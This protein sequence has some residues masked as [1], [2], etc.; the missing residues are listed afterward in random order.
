[1]AT[2]QLTD[3]YH[4]SLS[5]GKALWDDL[6]GTALPVEIKSGHFD[7]GK[8]AHNGVKQLGVKDRVVA[9]LED[10]EGRETAVTKFRDRAADLWRSRR[11]DVYELL[12]QVV[13]VEGDWKLE[14]DREGTEFHYGE[15]QI[16]VDAHVK[17][18]ASGTAQLLGRNVE[19]PFTLEKRLGAACHLGNIRF[20]QDLNAVIG[21]IKDPKIDFGDHVVMRLINQAAAQLLA[22][23]VDRF[24]PVPILKRDQL[25]EMVKPAGG[26]L[27][28]TMGVD[29]VQ[30][31]VTDGDLTLKL[32]FGF[33]TKQLPE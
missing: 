9:L 15:Q 29:D 24:N 16:G 2:K 12:D 27:N 28:M 18:V 26:P 11:E 13:H 4:L 32:K 8:L 19:V 20:D 1:M 5:I 23:Q 3:G 22:Q 14:V 7:L 33:N 10:K 17:A 21:E 31:V 6:V 25:E 30:I